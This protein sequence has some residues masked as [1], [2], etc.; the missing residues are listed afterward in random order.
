MTKKDLISFYNHVL[1]H[2]TKVKSMAD[3]WYDFSEASFDAENVKVATPG[4]VKICE[5]FAL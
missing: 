3:M 2:K 5:Q 1:K 4:Y